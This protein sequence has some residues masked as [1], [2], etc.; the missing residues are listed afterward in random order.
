MRGS[1]LDA[2]WAYA[3]VWIQW[4]ALEVRE[5]RR[6]GARQRNSYQGGRTFSN[7]SAITGKASPWTLKVESH[8]FSLA[9]YT[10]TFMRIVD[11]EGKETRHTHSSSPNAVS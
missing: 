11:L 1:W 5:E 9:L 2:V 4:L 8:S 7:K 6:Q 3:L 10:I